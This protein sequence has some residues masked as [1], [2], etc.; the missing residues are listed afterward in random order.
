MSHTDA[1]HKGSLHLEQSLVDLAVKLIQPTKIVLF[2]SRARGDHRPTSV[3]DFAFFFH[4]KPTPE[5]WAE[6]CL[7]AEET[8]PTLAALD[9]VPYSEAHAPLKASIDR[10]GLVIYEAK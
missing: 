8:L 3:Y 10:E 6:F 2:G 5:R 9:L 1:T 7:E 4:G